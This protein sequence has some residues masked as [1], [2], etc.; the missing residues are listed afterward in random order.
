MR[1][2]PAIG[3]A[4]QLSIRSRDVEAAVLLIGWRRWPLR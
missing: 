1:T 3:R 2:A 4:A